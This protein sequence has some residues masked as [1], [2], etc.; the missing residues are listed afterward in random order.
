[1]VGGGRGVRSFSAGATH[2]NDPG[3]SDSLLMQSME[4][5]IKEELN[6]E[7]VS[8]KDAYGDEPRHD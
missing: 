7:Y 5:K 6:A 1:M 8:V 3:S 4:K 2:D